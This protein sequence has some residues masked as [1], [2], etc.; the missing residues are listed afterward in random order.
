MPDTRLFAFKISAKLHSDLSDISEAEHRS[1]A[2][3]IRCMLEE[4][5]AE[6]QF[7]NRQK[8]ETNR[9]EAELRGKE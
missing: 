9:L 6:H 7:R 4:S 1:L 3:Q 5:I 2:G 8:R